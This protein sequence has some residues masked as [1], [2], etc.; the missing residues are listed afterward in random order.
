MYK[1]NSLLNFDDITQQSTMTNKYTVVVVVV[2]W[3][4]GSGGSS[5][6]GGGGSGDIKVGSREVVYTNFNEYLKKKLCIYIYVVIDTIYSLF[7]L[8]IL[9][10]LIKNRF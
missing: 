1:W 7:T 10:I 4:C 8:L 9:L 3:W 6:G 5:G 2:W